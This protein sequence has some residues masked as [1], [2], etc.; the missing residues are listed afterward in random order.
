LERGTSLG[1][2]VLWDDRTDRLLWVDIHYIDTPTNRV[3][4]FDYDMERGDISNRRVAFEITRE[5]G[6][7]D[8]MTIDTEGNLW[9][10]HYGGGCV[11]CWDPR[12]G[13]ILEAVDV[14]GARSITSCAFGGTNRSTL[15]I[16]TASRHMSEQER[17]EYPASGFLFAAETSARGRE[18]FEFGG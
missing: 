11:R 4:A 10:A 9:V 12:T 7:P 14:P 1:E 17:A 16:T 13:E 18:T 8:G 3:D 6:G 2:G 5:Q 15:Y